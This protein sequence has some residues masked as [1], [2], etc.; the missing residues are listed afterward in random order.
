MEMENDQH[1]TK[2]ESNFFTRIVKNLEMDRGK[3]LLGYGHVVDIASRDNHYSAFPPPGSY[4]EFA[5]FHPG[6]AAD[7]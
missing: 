5:H 1:F 2:I 7:R 4:A 6:G 3:A